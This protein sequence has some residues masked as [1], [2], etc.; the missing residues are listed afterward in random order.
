MGALE[1]IIEKLTTIDSNT[2]DES[3]VMAELNKLGSAN[4]IM[5]LV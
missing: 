3:L 4:P 5:A 2:N 1:L